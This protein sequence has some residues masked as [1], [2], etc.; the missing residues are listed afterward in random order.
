[1][2]EKIKRLEEFVKCITADL[3]TMTVEDVCKKYELYVYD[4]QV[5]YDGYDDYYFNTKDGDFSGC[6]SCESESNMGYLDHELEI[7]DDDVWDWRWRYD[8]DYGDYSQIL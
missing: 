8:T 6:L 3:E 5:N 2:E 7:W 1:M 4:H